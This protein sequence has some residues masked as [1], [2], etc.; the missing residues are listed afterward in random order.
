MKK[1][2]NLLLAAQFAVLSCSSGGQ[3]QQT[4][5]NGNLRIDQELY[6]LNI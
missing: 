2:L 4:I 3:A 1:L 6:G 5:D